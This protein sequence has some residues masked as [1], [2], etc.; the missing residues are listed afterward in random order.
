MLFRPDPRGIPDEQR[1]LAD[2]A[3]IVAFVEKS[4]GLR[5]RWRGE[6]QISQELNNL[7][8]PKY[9]GRKLPDCPIEY[10]ESVISNVEMYYVGFEEALHSCSV[11]YPTEGQ[12]L[13]RFVGWEEATVASCLELL[14]PRFRTL[15]SEDS[16]PLALLP[17]TTL[18]LHYERQ[19]RAL[20]A[21]RRLREDFYFTLLS[22]SIAY[23][24]ML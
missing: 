21:L 7:G 5:S 3:K 19:M 12:D 4:T 24:F 1:L 18:P 11:I 13:R 17:D 2:T 22:R 23:S 16:R 8:E 10:H 14:K 9:L 20:G 15:F 6:I